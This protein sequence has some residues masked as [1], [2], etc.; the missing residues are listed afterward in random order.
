MEEHQD[1]S[2][3]HLSSF[4]CSHN[5]IL[6]MSCSSYI[7]PCFYLPQ[8]INHVTPRASHFREKHGA[9]LMSRSTHFNS[10][11]IFLRE[12]DSDKLDSKGRHAWRRKLCCL[13]PP[14]LFSWR[15]Q[16]LG[17]SSQTHLGIMKMRILLGIFISNDWRIVV[18]IRIGKQQIIMHAV[19]L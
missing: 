2:V 5:V 18:S 9:V 13:G 12:P 1:Y 3:I 7:F 16:D 4:S 6:S 19:F 14:A 17:R 10:Q 8:S 15:A 11:Q